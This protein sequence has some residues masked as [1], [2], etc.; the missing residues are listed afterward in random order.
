MLHGKHTV[1]IADL[2]TV[3]SSYSVLGIRLYGCENVPTSSFGNKTTQYPNGDLILAP[4]AKF[5]FLKFCFSLFW[6]FFCFVCLSLAYCSITHNLIINLKT[7]IGISIGSKSTEA[8]GSTFYTRTFGPLTPLHCKIS[9]F[10]N[11]I[12]C[13]IHILLVLNGFMLGGIFNVCYK[14]KLLIQIFSFQTFQTAFTWSHYRKSGIGFPGL[15]FF[16]RIY[17]SNR[18]IQCENIPVCF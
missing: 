10:S 3:F 1:S 18:I 2:P 11:I 16:F 6:V 17:W 4:V 13:M 12:F 5:G 7:F 9:F 8:S 15:F 14:E